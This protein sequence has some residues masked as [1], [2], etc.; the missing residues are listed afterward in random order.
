MTGSENKNLRRLP[1]I[2]LLLRS[3]ELASA[4]ERFG[5]EVV[6]EAAREVLDEARESIRQSSGKGFISSDNSESDLGLIDRICMTA[7]ANCHPALIPVFN[8]TGT[9][10]HTN[11]GRALLPVEAMDALRE[12][13]GQAVNLE[14]DLATGTRG[15]RESQVEKLI[16]VLTGAEAA[17]VVNNNAAAVVLVL[18][19]LAV[20]REVVISRGSW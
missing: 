13:A 20:G 14:Y 19:S 11:L 7:A 15:D 17:T 16:C 12:V 18:T 6:R 5:R 10:I 4:I 8:L 3:K 1:S 9:V 2:D